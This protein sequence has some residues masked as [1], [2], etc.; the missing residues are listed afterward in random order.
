D[1]DLRH[2]YITCTKNPG[3]EQ[4]IPIKDLTLDDFPGALR[5][6][7]VLD[8]V[9]ALSQ[10]VVRLKVKVT[11]S[12]RPKEDPFSKLVGRG[13][14]RGATGSVCH[15]VDLDNIRV[16][17]CKDD[18]IL[19]GSNHSVYGFIPVRTNRHVVHDAKEAESTEVE[20]FFDTPDRL[21]VVTLKGHDVQ[22]DTENGECVIVRC[23]THDLDFI[24]KVH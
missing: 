10:L 14:L 2:R 20:C 22:R 5:Y 17:P 19:S 3:H 15:Q 21:G 11:S 7:S 24:K 6:Q 13:V 12:D 9:I 23:V 8:Y 1:S 4:F 18:C 16:L